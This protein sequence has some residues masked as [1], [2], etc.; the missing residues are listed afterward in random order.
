MEYP[1]KLIQMIIN[2]YKNPRTNVS[3]A[4][5]QTEFFNLF[6]GTTQG[7][8]LSPLIFVIFLDPLLRWLEA[9]TPGYKCAFSS[10][11]ATNMGYVDD[12]LTPQNNVRSLQKAAGLI[13]KYSI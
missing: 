3:T 13:H 4:L 5:G 11:T 2:I 12:L 6:R 8:S 1:K 7:D 10:H 9:A